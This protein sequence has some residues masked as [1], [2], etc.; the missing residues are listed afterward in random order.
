MRKSLLLTALFI[1]LMSLASLFAAQAQSPTPVNDG[2]ALT[3]FSQTLTAQ[4]A[5]ATPQAA[6]ATPTPGRLTDEPFEIAVFYNDTTLTLLAFGAGTVSLEGIGV[7]VPGGRSLDLSGMRVLNDITFEELAL[8]FCLHLENSQAVRNVPDSC[9]DTPGRRIRDI[10]PA[11]VIWFDSAAEVTQAIQIMRYNEVQGECVDPDTLC[12]VTYEPLAPLPTALPS[13]TPTQR[14]SGIRWTFDVNRLL[15]TGVE[16]Q[17]SDIISVEAS[18]T[19]IAGQ[20]VGALGPDGKER[21]D[22]LP[23]AIDPSY[24]VEQA[25]AHGALMVRIGSSGEWML[26]GSSCEFNAPATGELQFGI[27]D[28]NINDN[29]GSFTVTV[30]LG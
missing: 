13:T 28:N 21:L 17:Q 8:P 30:T 7:R 4:A 20:F 2:I 9:F 11:D 3:R 29:S 18:G 24:D 16:V 26:C 23:F 5:T 15:E 25:F 12:L 19:I 1:L 6:T 27:N 22:A 10:S 14:A